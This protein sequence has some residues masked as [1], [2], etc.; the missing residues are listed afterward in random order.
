MHLRY[1]LGSFFTSTGERRHR[2]QRRSQDSHSRARQACLAAH[3]ASSMALHLEEPQTTYLEAL[4]LLLGWFVGW[5][6]PLDTTSRLASAGLKSDSGRVRGVELRPGH[7]TGND[8]QDARSSAVGASEFPATMSRSLPSAIA[9][10]KRWKRLEPGSSRRTSAQSA[11][12]D[13]GA[14][15]L[16]NTIKNSWVSAFALLFKTYMRPVGWTGAARVSSSFRQSKEFLEPRAGGLGSSRDGELGQLGKTGE[17]DTSVSL[18]LA[19]QQF[20]F[21]VLRFAQTH[22]R[23]TTAPL[24][25]LVH[26]S[27]KVGKRVEAATLSTTE[28][29]AMCPPTRR[30]RARTVLSTPK[31]GRS[32]ETRRRKVFNSGRRYEKHARLSL[33]CPRSHQNFSSKEQPSNATWND[34]GKGSKACAHWTNFEPRT[35]SLCIFEAARPV[36]TILSGHGM[37]SSFWTLHADRRLTLDNLAWLRQCWVGLWQARGLGM[38]SGTSSLNSEQRNHQF[39]HVGRLFACLCCARYPCW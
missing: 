11:G 31:P 1:R 15:A 13:G 33:F 17:C 35:S 28:D 14:L 22:T 5:L 20:L 37:H 16:Q 4:R 26:A 30:A 7:N 19:R 27:D 23:R 29:H 38:W 24:S 36:C 39:L 6:A 2:R 21:P 8:Q 9:C 12:A 34:S 32:T 3:L 18:D 25:H 10:P